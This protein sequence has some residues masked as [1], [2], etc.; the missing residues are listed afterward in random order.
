[1]SA[2][3]ARAL[4]YRHT[5]AAAARF[6]LSARPWI[7]TRTERSAASV[8]S[9]GRPFASLPNSHCVGARKRSAIGE[10]VQV[11]DVQSRP[12]R[13]RSGRRHGPRRSPPPGSRPR[14]CRGE[15]SFRPTRAQPCRCTRRRC[16]RR[17][18]PRPRRRHPRCAR[19]CR[20]FRDRWRGRGRPPTGRRAPEPSRAARQRLGRPPRGPAATPSRTASPPPSS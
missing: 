7:G 14:R 17:T 1:M 15:T 16:D 10:V 6:R 18:P 9:A 4:A 5:A 8:T 12:P 2:R 19:S 11:V 3:C 13:A 20:R